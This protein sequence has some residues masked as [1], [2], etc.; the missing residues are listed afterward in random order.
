MP[1]CIKGL[2]EFI[3]SSCVPNK[4]EI[5]RVLDWESRALVSAPRSELRKSFSSVVQ[6]NECPTFQ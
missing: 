4:G 6:E 2:H 1:L 5:F 3:C